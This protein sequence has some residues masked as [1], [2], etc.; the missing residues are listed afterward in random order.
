[1]KIRKLKIGEEIEYNDYVIHSETSGLLAVTLNTEKVHKLTID[2]I[3]VSLEDYEEK[4]KFCD[5][6]A[7][8]IERFDDIVERQIQ[9]TLDCMAMTFCTL[10][11]DFKQIKRNFYNIG[12]RM[13]NLIA[14]LIWHDVGSKIVKE[15]QK[16]RQM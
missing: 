1:M 12:Y 6:W 15:Y 14:L 2:L 10:K 5:F 7:D 3:K 4:E 13:E 11:D 8:N 16:E 9:Y